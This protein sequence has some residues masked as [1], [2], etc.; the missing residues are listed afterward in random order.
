M[1]K[2]PNNSIHPNYD[3]P[4][5]SHHFL[6]PK[7]LSGFL[8]TNST[9][10]FY[11]CLPIVYFPH[12]S[13][14]IFSNINQIILFPVKLSRGFLSL[15]AYKPNPLSLSAKLS[16]MMWPCANLPNSSVCPS[17]DP[18][19]PHRPSCCS[20][21]RSGW[22]PLRSLYFPFAPPGSPCLWFW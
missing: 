8:T 18:L 5:T 12:R 1:R 22:S 17:L 14:M 16:Y 13:Q 3:C 4:C 2:M 7:L 6:V 9:L 20:F 19:Q 11:S 21:N 10:C 15:L